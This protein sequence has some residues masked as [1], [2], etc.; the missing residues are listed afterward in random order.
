MLRVVTTTAMTKGEDNMVDTMTGTGVNDSGTF[1][2]RFEGTIATIREFYKG[3]ECQMQ[4]SDQYMLDTLECEGA[5]FLRL[6]R[7]CLG[8][9][10]RVNSMRGPAP[11]TWEKEASNAMCYRTMPESCRRH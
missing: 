1:R 4:F 8:R 10:R 9:E 5:S 7:G 11:T 3:L 2:D 6:A